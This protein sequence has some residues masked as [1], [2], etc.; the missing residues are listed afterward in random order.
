MADA[1][2]KEYLEYIAKNTH[3]QTGGHIDEYGF[4]QQP[5][6]SSFDPEGYYFNKAGY[7]EFGGYYDENGE[8]C[9]QE[10][11]NVNE[12]YNEDLKD[13]EVPKGFSDE[14]PAYDPTKAPAGS[15]FEAT[16]T[17][18]SYRATKS[19]IEAE[20]KNLGIE[21]KNLELMNDE[22]GKIMQVK[23]VI[24]KVDSAKKLYNMDE[25]AFLHRPLHVSM[26]DYMKPGKP[27]EK[28]TEEKTAE[29]KKQPVKEGAPKKTL[30]K[31][32]ENAKDNDIFTF[33]LSS[34]DPKFQKQEVREQLTKEG[35]NVKK[36]VIVEDKKKKEAPCW[37]VV[38]NDKKS[39]I[40]LHELSGEPILG[41][42]LKVDLDKVDTPASTKP[43]VK[44]P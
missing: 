6:G 9:E 7:D 12:D 5:D 25:E 23:L 36:I 43:E 18:I 35:I 8:Y 41:S 15:I 13:I 30:P 42:K 2:Q 11:E 16:L 14:V 29:E 39:A 32:M 22:E 44:K 27:E 33:K 37:R 4:Y 40:K 3:Y 26:K 28:K 1:A 38:I 17:N 34:V 31:K 10:D 21:Y 19:E 24:E 20:L